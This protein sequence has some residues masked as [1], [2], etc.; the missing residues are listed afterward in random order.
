MKFT[1]FYKT[2]VAYYHAISWNK[3][4]VGLNFIDNVRKELDLPLLPLERIE[5]TCDFLFSN[6]E[7]EIS[8]E[9]ARDSGHFRETGS[10]EV[11]VPKKSLNQFCFVD[12]DIEKSEETGEILKVRPVT[13][14]NEDKLLR[15]W[16]ENGYPIEWDLQEKE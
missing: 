2:K 6:P 12:S 3:R 10:I 13:K 16:K 9:V 8:E 5:I 15:A 4:K 11:Y 7:I 1:V 14:L